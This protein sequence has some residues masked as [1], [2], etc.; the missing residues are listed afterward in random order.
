V[1]GKGSAF[2]RDV[3]KL[4]SK[5]VQGSEKPYLFWRQPSSGGLATISELNSDL[6]GDIRAVNPKGE[7]FANI[8]SIECKNGYPKTSFWQHLKEIKNFNI[9][10][11]WIQCCDDAEKSDRRP[12][13][14]YRKKGMKPFIAIDGITDSIL[15]SKIDGL[16][17][18]PSFTM[19]WRE[20]L[21]EISIYD[22]KK[23]FKIVKPKDIKKI[24][25][26][27]KSIWLK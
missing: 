10:D 16:I 17:E 23:F 21:L 4:L 8:F 6:S 15:R 22:M 27:R 1:S 18:L 2:E 25:K 9:K 3:C 13:L 7:F 11:F 19:R 20:N 24:F 26:R 12:M 14:I 5:W